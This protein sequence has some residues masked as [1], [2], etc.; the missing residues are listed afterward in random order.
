MSDT[1]QSLGGLG[2]DYR[3][4]IRHPLTEAVIQVA[5]VPAPNLLGSSGGLSS[6]YDG[7]VP[8][9]RITLVAFP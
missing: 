5:P 4:A 6:F 1:G 2:L 8:L 7:P 9:G 3:G